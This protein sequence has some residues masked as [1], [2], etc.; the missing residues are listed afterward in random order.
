MEK[1]YSISVVEGDTGIGRDT[2]RIWERRYGYPGPVRGHKG[3][4]RYPLSQVVQRLQLIRRLL[5]QGLGQD[6]TLKCRWINWCAQQRSSSLMLS[7]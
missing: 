7:A 4:R 5:D 1:S 2:L 6:C 3:E